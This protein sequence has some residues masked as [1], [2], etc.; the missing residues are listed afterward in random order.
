[1]RR[2]SDPGLRSRRLFLLGATSLASALALVPTGVSGQARYSVTPYVASDGALYGNPVVSGL[3]VGVQSGAL[4]VRPSL[5]IGWH[6]MRGWV[7]LGHADGPITAADGSTVSAPTPWTADVNVVLS[8]V[9][10][11][12][13][14]R[15]L[16][17][18][19]EP[20]LFVGVG[21]NGGADA[22][23]KGSWAPTFSY[24]GGLDFP[25]ARWL[26]VQSQLRRRITVEDLGPGHPGFNDGWEYRAGLSVRFGGARS[27][28]YGRRVGRPVAVAP[29]RAEKADETAA[30]QMMADR[31]IDAAAENIGT[32]YVWGGEQPGQ[33]FDCSGLVQY[34][35]GQ[36][37]I[38]LPRTSADQAEAGYSI[39]GSF[40]DAEAGDLLFFAADGRHVDHVA[41]S[42][43]GT[44]I[45]HASESGGGVRFDEL[46]GAR[47]RWYVDHL[48]DVR[49]AIV[50]PTLPVRLLSADDAG[51]GPGH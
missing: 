38:R 28:S 48:V 33:G 1:M 6:T 42:A 22:D 35:F 20:T 9:V 44:R 45:I 51:T 41:I 31:I 46:A 50:P 29:R 26:A 43:G 32:P 47:G 8:P 40:R 14:L 10:L 37:G 25:L 7:G 39:G 3:A 36:Q 34:V 18:S 27:G 2:C 11:A 23:G 24:G 17:G 5:G 15:S 21:A 30:R 16:T 4:A 19:V 12:P 13:A 49:R